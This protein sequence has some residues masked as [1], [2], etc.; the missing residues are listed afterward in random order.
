MIPEFTLI[1][2]PPVLR[3]IP[4]LVAIVKE[5]V[6][7]KVPPLNVNCVATEDPGAVPKLSSALIEIVPAEIVVIP[8]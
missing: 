3:V 5:A 6:V 1:V 7:C 2:P 8:E 4:L